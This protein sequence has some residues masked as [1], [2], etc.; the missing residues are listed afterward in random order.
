MARQPKPPQPPSNQQS[1]EQGSAEEAA[2]KDPE[3]AVA[4]GSMDHSQETETIGA[5][6]HAAASG[7]AAET[8][9]GRT[10]AP[11]ELLKQILEGY[12]KAS[13]LQAD[14]QSVYRTLPAIVGVAGEI[15]KKK[16]A[17]DAALQ[18]GV[19]AVEK[20]LKDARDKAE[21]LSK[22]M[23]AQQTALEEL[24]KNRA[25]LTELLKTSRSKIS[26]S[27]VAFPQ[28]P[29]EAAALAD[30]KVAYQLNTLMG[31]INSMVAREVEKQ[32]AG[33][34]AQAE[35]TLQQAQSRK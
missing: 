30:P 19:G 15:L 5:E 18:E 7:K 22:A 14:Y 13:N 2:K 27:G 1:A 8:R 25:S 23:A 12:L 21:D 32:I 24:L 35:K 20:V 34:R 9:A 6:G 16:E 17:G 29:T 10:N 4:S 31:N 3:A 33:L 11:S 26:A 28:V